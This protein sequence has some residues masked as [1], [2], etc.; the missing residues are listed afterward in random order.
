MSSVRTGAELGGHSRIGI[1]QIPNL[2]N[3]GGAYFEQMS[4]LST[5]PLSHELQQIL[6]LFQCATEQA[7]DSRDTCEWIV[8]IL[9]IRSSPGG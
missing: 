8:I 9:Q 1:A 5:S 6:E 2:P 4:T 3:W 7:A